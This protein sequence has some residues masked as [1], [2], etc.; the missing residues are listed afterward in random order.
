MKP[1]YIVSKHEVGHLLRKSR[2]AKKLTADAVAEA[3][4]VSGMTYGRW[5]DGENEGGCIQVSRAAAFLGMTPNEIFV[6]PRIPKRADERLSSEE[7]AALRLLLKELARAEDLCRHYG[8][9]AIAITADF[10]RR[11][12]DKNGTVNEGLFSAEDVGGRLKGAKPRK[13]KG[14]PGNESA[15]GGSMAAEDK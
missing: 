11:W 3:A 10:L 6:K 4:G 1:S 13:P 8:E 14:K 12:N 9:S 5:E 15:G 2:E 7:R